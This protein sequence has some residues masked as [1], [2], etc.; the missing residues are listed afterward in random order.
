[1]SGA[2]VADLPVLNP[3]LDAKSLAKDFA[4]RG[5]IHIPNFLEDAS[6]KV[7]R[8]LVTQNIPWQVTYNEGDQ[9]YE[10][11]TAQVA[12]MPQHARQQMLNGI[13]SRAQ[14]GFQFV[15]SHYLISEAIKAGRDTGHPAHMLHDFVNDE[16]FLTFMRALTGEDGIV[17]S[18]AM[19]A[20]YDRGHFLSNHDDEHGDHDRIAAWVLNLTPNWHPNWGGHLIFFDEDGNITEGF[21]PTYNALNVLR[22]PQRHAVAFVAPFA[23]ASRITL[24]GWVRRS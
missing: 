7:V 6:A 21:L 2:A 12:R 3:Q 14:H 24:T 20:R 15:Y 10:V 13:M 8:D 4:E 19:A 5:R 23:G 17:L 22:V 1:M 9:S 11:D 18:D 16:P